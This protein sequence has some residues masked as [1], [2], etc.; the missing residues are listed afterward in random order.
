MGGAGS[1]GPNV[2]IVEATFVRRGSRTSVCYSGKQAGKSFLT[3]RKLPCTEL[4]YAT[5]EHVFSLALV[6]KREGVVEVVLF[7]YS[8]GKYSASMGRAPNCK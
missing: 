5:A 6:V 3:Y 8:A 7:R 2:A 4:A 1:F